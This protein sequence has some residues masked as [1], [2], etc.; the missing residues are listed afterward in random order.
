MG[1]HIAGQNF[2]GLTQEEA[3]K[4]LKELAE[5]AQKQPL[6]VV[7][8]G[9]EWS[10]SAADFKVDVDVATTVSAA[11]SV[12]RGHGLLRDLGARI[13][14]YFSPKDVEL[15]GTLDEDALRAFVQEVAEKVDQP[16]RNP[17]L[18]FQG[19]SIMVKEG[20]RGWVLDRED[21]FNR[22]ESTLLS[23]HDTRV[24]AV[25]ILSD[26]AVSA[27]AAESAVQ[28]A[29]VMI[30]A[31]VVLTYEDK[32]WRLDGAQIQAAIDC[33]VE[34]QGEQARLVPVISIAKAKS[35]FDAVSREVAIEAVD[36][37]WETDGH[38]AR[39]L[40]AQVGRELDVAMT[41]VAITKAAKSQKNRVAEAVVKVV[42]P[43]LSTE[44]A[45]SM[46]IEAAIGSFKT[47]F[48]GTPNRIANIARAAEL[49]N[50]T[51]L[52][53][54]QEFSFNKVVGERTEERGFHTAKVV[55][56]DGTLQDD[57]GGGICQVATTLFNAALTAGLKITERKN[58]SRYFE[59]Y[60]KGRDATVSWEGPD[61]RFLNDTEHWILIKAAATKTS[62]T[63]VIYGT[64]D[65]RTVSISTS[66]WYE[67]WPKTTQEVK[68]S[69]LPA[70]QKRVKD[71]G[72]DGRSCTVVRVVKASDGRV[73]REDVF[74]SRYP[75]CP[76]IVEVG[77]KTG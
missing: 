74:E 56:P 62:L 15:R 44:K 70:G 3:I 52:A 20:A 2:G 38:K 32:K 54:G 77:T 11:M 50:G 27:S 39:L 76:R 6:T 41:A 9:E 4:R 33:V 40:E 7:A 1:V 21:L 53:P 57:L 36:A 67:V 24:E 47:E 8:D 55:A 42:E 28:Q 29:K 69:D 18:I 73:I 14:C 43:T 48:E 71:E 34:G 68:T 45:A 17:S 12:T 13:G 37:T 26:P 19:S 22:L 64:P 60:P 16:A 51:L 5:Q 31:P 65:G 61:L 46:G 75:M 58:H 59:A 30:S 49:I 35:F 72:Q 10:V 23:L 63:F 66:D 25:M